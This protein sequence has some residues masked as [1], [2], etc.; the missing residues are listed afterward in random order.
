MRPS[1]HAYEKIKK[2]IDPKDGKN[3]SYRPRILHNPGFMVLQPLSSGED[4]TVG[5]ITSK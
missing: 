3:E 4:L 1:A 5:Y 2:G